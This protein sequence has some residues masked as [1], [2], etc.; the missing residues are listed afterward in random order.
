MGAQQKKHKKNLFHIEIFF[1][2]M[3]SSLYAV[4]IPFC[5]FIFAV[6]LLLLLLIIIYLFANSL[7]C[8]LQQRVSLLNNL[9]VQSSL[10]SRIAR[11]ANQR[12]FIPKSINGII[13][14]M[15]TLYKA[16]VKSFIC[17][18]IMILLIAVQLRILR[19][20]LDHMCTK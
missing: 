6:F 16:H 1:A 15:H 10:G 18:T 9:V 13:C 8:D 19:L 7:L 20:K 14:I 11:R 3:T 17:N 12:L 2:L 5:V 4:F